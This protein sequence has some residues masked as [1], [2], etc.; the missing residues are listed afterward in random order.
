[1]K[2]DNAL[3]SRIMR[4]VKGKDTAPELTVRRLAHSLGYRYRLHRSD[5]AGKPDLVFP[6]RHKIIFVHG[7][8]W[9]GHACARGDRQP[10]TNAAY[11]RTKISRNQSRDF[12]HLQ[13]LQA[14]RWR[15]LTIW[16][17]ETKNAAALTQRL[18]SFLA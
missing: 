6:G 2:E 3:R 13:S 14:Q 8:F 12:R 5:L 11:W 10:K 17:C 16:E 15:V 4:A 7:C 18:R 1:V 9:H